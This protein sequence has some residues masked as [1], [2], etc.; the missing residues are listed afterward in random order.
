MSFEKTVYFRPAYDKRDPEPAINYGVGSVVITFYLK[1][2]KGVIQFVF[3]TDWNLPHVT[4]ERKSKPKTHY[5][6]EYPNAWD[7]GYHSPVPQY[8]GQEPFGECPLLDGAPCYHDRSATQAKAFLENL[9]SGGSDAVWEE[10][11]QFYNSTFDQEEV[12]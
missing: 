9:I 3:S 11:L 7:I 12:L 1:G 4:A 5:D 8:E 6:L 2:E 10:M